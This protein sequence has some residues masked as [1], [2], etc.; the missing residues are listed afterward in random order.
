MV[1]LGRA[2]FAHFSYAQ[3]E[4]AVV[5]AGVCRRDLHAARNQVDP[6][7]DIP[8][9]ADCRR[10]FTDLPLDGAVIA[11]PPAA[12]PDIAMAAIEGGVPALFLEKPGAENAAALSAVADAAARC[13]TEVL[14]GYPRRTR[15]DLDLA[16]KWM[17][18]DAAGA[19]FTIEA[20]WQE[21]FERWFDGPPAIDTGFRTSP[22]PARRGA[23]LESG[24]HAIETLL[25]LFGPVSRVA[26]ARLNR[27]ARGLDIGGEAALVFERGHRARL[28]LSTSGDGPRRREVIASSGNLEFWMDDTGSAMQVGAQRR[29]FAAQRPE[30]AQWGLFIDAMAGRPNGRACTLDQAVAVLTVVDAIYWRAGAAL[31]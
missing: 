5:V 31:S 26:E 24:C 19:N 3:F 7:G 6:F 18:D 12:T 10:M 17:A 27:G 2:G 1:G 20:H 28:R 14:V 13:G 15:P 4:S 21:D 22:T 8:C 29:E 11:T 23:M 9:F 16:R 25:R 30:A